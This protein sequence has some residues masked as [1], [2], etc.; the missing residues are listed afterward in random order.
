MHAVITTFL[1]DL[2]FELELTGQVALRLGAAWRRRQLIADQLFQSGI[3]VVHVV[4]LV[5]V[6]IGM[7]VALQTGIELASFGQQ[8][9][10]GTIV[11]L[12]MCREMGPFIT[13]TI[14][15][16]TVGGAL[17]AEIGT[18]AV[19]D[20]LAA[21]EVMSID[22]VAFLVMPRVVAV[23]VACP[24][25]TVL[26]DLIGIVGGGLIADSQLN[27]DLALYYDSVVDALDSNGFVFD[28]PKDV[29]TGLFKAFVFGV[30]L[31]VIS[32]AAG[33]Q[34]SS[35]ATGVGNA[36]R[37]AVRDSIIAI[38]IANYFLSWAFFNA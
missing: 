7:I 20:E 13:A 30:I 22:R 5:G 12:S 27:V 10:I 8:D 25:L 37:K 16:A 33:M 1:K 3:K 6:F 14:L 38:I 31:S 11:A 26:C 32:C 34:A 28:L 19:S 18:M 29:Y 21:L 24:M 35:G 36:T 17:A 2:G 15:A 23:A 9:Q 4:L